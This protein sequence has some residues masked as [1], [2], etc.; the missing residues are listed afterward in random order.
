MSQET[1]LVNK[2]GYEIR[3]DMLTLAQNILQYQHES[4]VCRLK[5]LAD[6]A[7]IE[8]LQTITNPTSWPAAPTVENILEKAHSLYDFVNRSENRHNK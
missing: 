4:E 1:K 7:D 5:L 2:N 8:T 3:A 6:K